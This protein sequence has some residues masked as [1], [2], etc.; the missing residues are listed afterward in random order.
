MEKDR[1]NS[2][3]GALEG[4]VF[5][6]YEKPSET[7]TKAFVAKYKRDPGITADT[8]YDAVIVYAKAVRAVN[9]L[10]TDEVNKEL[11]S[12]SRFEGASGTFSFDPKGAVDKSPVLWRIS[13]KEYLRENL[14]TNIP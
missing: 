8:A 6:L 1:V 13:G 7:F 12:T 4:T 2:A 9:S 14:A 10:N 11:H 5:A 3:A